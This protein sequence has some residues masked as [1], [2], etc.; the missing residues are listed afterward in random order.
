MSYLL[1]T[2]LANILFPNPTLVSLK[3]Y[4]EVRGTSGSSLSS[5]PLPPSLLSVNSR[6]HSV[7][8]SL[9]DIDHRNH[10]FCSGAQEGT[11]VYDKRW[12]PSLNYWTLLIFCLNLSPAPTAILS[13]ENNTISCH[14]YGEWKLEMF[15][16]HQILATSVR[17]IW[18]TRISHHLL[19]IVTFALSWRASNLLTTEP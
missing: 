9:L 12:A 6:Y 14:S 3:A 17:E 11:Y 7:Y 16:I 19:K 2:R 15:T 13:S 1:E 10:L 18:R 8:S 5:G 4:V